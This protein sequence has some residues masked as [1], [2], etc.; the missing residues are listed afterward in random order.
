MS[1]KATTAK[2]PRKADLL[3]ALRGFT[4]AVRNAGGI[5]VIEGEPGPRRRDL[6]QAYRKACQ[7]LNETPIRVTNESEDDYTAQASYLLTKHSR[8]VELAQNRGYSTKA[9]VGLVMS[10]AMSENVKAMPF[11]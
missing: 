9:L 1:H 11:R 8:L 2:T 5:Q 4:E 6:A 3:A 7:A 10:A